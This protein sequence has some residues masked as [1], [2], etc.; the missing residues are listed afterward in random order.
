MA[1]FFRDVS[2]LLVSDG[3]LN[4]FDTESLGF[5]AGHRDQSSTRR[6]EPAIARLTT[7]AA[8]ANGTHPIDSSRPSGADCRVDAH[9]ARATN[10]SVPVCSSPSAPST[11]TCA[12]SSTNSASTVRPRSPSGL[13]QRIANSIGFPREWGQ[14][15]GSRSRVTDRV[16]A[17]CAELIVRTDLPGSPPYRGHLMSSQALGCS[18]PSARADLPSRSKC[19][20]R[21]RT[22]QTN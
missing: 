7:R 2:R 21:S 22:T 4:E 19:A 20:R 9:W 11:A 12:A 3:G 10:R 13:G 15:V 18:K 5:G 8:S 14:T 16:A 1:I 17:T 6:R